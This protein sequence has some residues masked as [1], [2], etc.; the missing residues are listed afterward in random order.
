MKQLH[1][2][3]NEE[4]RLN[5]GHL[6]IFANEVDVEKSPLPAFEPG[7][8]VTVLDSRGRELGSATVN[9]HS[10]I[11]ARLH[12]RKPDTPL[13]GALLAERLRAALDLRERLFPDPFYRLCHGE[14]D[15]LPGLVLDRFGAHLTIQLGTAAMDARRDLLREIL[16]DLLHPASVLIDNDIPARDLEG[17][18][19]ETVAAENVPEELDVPENG[20]RFL[21]PCRTGQKTGWFYDQRRNRAEAAR[22]AAGGDV[23]DVFCYAGGFGATAA[24]S[25]AKSVTFVDASAQAL[26]FALRNAARNAPDAAAEAVC[27]NAFDIMR[28]LHDEGLRFSLVCLDPP[29]FVRRRKDLARGTAAYRKANLLAVRLLAPGGVLVSCSC[30]HHLPADALRDALAAAAAKCGRSGQF[31]H[32]GG[33]PEDHPVHAS[34]P[35][36]AYLKCFLMRCA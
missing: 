3:R 7:E 31:L 33:Q 9:P 10:L 32:A 2:R 6:W 28:K 12:S 8:D 15:S 27:G 36:T 18:S 13:D 14:G 17:L 11:C 21:A 4:R 22:H 30:S 23:L 19:R 34:M 26:D 20:L 5:G 35:E 29:A 25:G 16:D 1:L 24:A